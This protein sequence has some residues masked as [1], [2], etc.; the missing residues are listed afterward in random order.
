MHE[1]LLHHP[2]EKALLLWVGALGQDP[3][4]VLYERRKH[5]PV[6]GGQ[7]HLPLVSSASGFSELQQLVVADPT[8]SA[9]RAGEADPAGCV[10]RRPR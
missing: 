7:F 9:F 2:A 5:V 1:D 4:E 8:T 10:R 6:D 3:L